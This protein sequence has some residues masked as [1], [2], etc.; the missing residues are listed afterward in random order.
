MATYSEKPTTFEEIVAPFDP[1]VQATAEALRALIRETLPDF[2]ENI[3]GGLSVANAL[4]SR[5]GPNHVV[6]GIQPA[7]DHCKLYVHHVADVRRDGIRIEGSGKNVRHVK[8]RKADGETVNLL[9]WLLIEA[10]RRSGL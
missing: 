3:Y 1:D 4:Y 2:D 10:R 6:C 9:G 5:G 8:V 7:R